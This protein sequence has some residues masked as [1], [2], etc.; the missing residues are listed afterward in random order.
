MKNPYVER[1]R[2]RMREFHRHNPWRLDNGL[3]IPHAYP[4]ESEHAALSW[5]DDVGFVLNGRRVLVFWRHP[6]CVYR[7]AIEA[8]AMADVAEPSTLDV[9]D[10]CFHEGSAS[11][12][13]WRKL[14]R[15]RKKVV[16]T[17]LQ[18]PTEEWRAYF[19]AVRKRER[20][21]EDTGIDFDVTSSARIGWCSTATTID[22]IAP[23]EVRS[24]TDVRA[25]AAF[26]KRLVRREVTLAGEWPGYRYGRAAW[27]AESVVRSGAHQRLDRE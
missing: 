7:D 20:E 16:S 14:G 15:S 23:L 18:A 6:R 5:W 1:I 19:D 24:E 4:P 21:L 22:L 9:F 10:A 25:L 11:I 13:Q 8:K 17:T 27:L 26:A 3:Y 2:R 12:K